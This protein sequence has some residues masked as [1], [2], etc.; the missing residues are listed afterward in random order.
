[1]SSF[2]D[3]ISG[4]TPT[5]VDFHATWCR[6]CHTMSPIIDEIKRRYGNKLRV[7]KVDVDKNQKASAK[8]KVRGVPTFLLFQRGEIKWRAAG[9]LTRRNLM[10]QIDALV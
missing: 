5:L 7:I 10:Q 8:Y 3:I 6:P 1:M 9:V 4:E 2:K